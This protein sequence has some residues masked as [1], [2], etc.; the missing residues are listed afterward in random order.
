[1]EA[2]EV[3]VTALRR[4]SRARPEEREMRTRI[5]IA[6]ISGVC[7]LVFA[8]SSAS[9]H[10]ANWSGD[11]AL[12]DV[13]SFEHP[14]QDPWAGWVNVTVTNTGTEAWGD[15]HFEIFSVGGYDVSNVDWIVAPPYEPTSSQS[16][17]TWAVDNVT[18]GATIDLFFYSDP[19]YPTETATFSV[20]NVNPDMV[21]FF[22][23][24]FYPTPVPEPASLVLLA[25]GA[26]G[27]RRR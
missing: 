3:C 9:A 24:A 4:G 16:P 18:V 21:P 11:L 19:V 2:E 27:L 5:G 6:A 22:G 8:I 7:I 17:L 25:L 1:M 23:V 20:Y 13:G 26:L 10:D 15:F 12:G 14:D